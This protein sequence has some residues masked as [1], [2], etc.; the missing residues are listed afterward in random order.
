MAALPETLDPTL[1]AL[2]AAMESEAAQESPRAYL[3]MSAIGE[4][5]DRKLWYGWR[6]MAEV[7]HDALTLAR[8]ADGHYSEDAVAARL[9][10][11]EGLELTTHLASGS[12]IGFSDMQGHFR[13]HMDGLITGLLQA[14]K[15]THVWEHKCVNETKFKKLAALKAEVGEKNALAKWDE[16]YYAQAVL[17]MH[18]AELDRHYLTCATAG[19]REVT[20]VRTESNS[21]YAKQLI[22]KAENILNASQPPAR[23]Y[24]DASFYKCKWCPF[25]EQCHFNAPVART[26]RSCAHAE[27]VEDGKWRCNFVGQNIPTVEDEASG[28]G[29]WRSLI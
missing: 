3:G 22:A 2:C 28:C 9:R 8:F 26:C 27:P 14:P 12:Q 10:K 21:E 15:T 18:Y 4:E 11:V 20:S 6:W 1:V 7:N 24:K 17:Y 19:S 13:G 25:S 5:C 16:I 29:S 23:A